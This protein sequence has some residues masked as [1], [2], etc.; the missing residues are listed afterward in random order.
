M[1]RNMQYKDIEEIKE[2]DRLCFKADFNRTAEG[3]QGYIEAG[4]NSSLV[5]EIDNKVVGFNF[6]HLWG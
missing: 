2:I 5:Y 1:I 6:I 4:F 3:I